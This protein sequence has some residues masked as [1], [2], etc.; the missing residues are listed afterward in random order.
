M[1]GMQQLSAGGK[2]QYNSTTIMVVLLSLSMF[3]LLEELKKLA[4][5]SK[6][7]N[8][9]TQHFLQHNDTATT[10]GDQHQK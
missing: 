8:L 9:A 5:L 2:L 1:D 10:G 7:H 6:R 3:A 4:S